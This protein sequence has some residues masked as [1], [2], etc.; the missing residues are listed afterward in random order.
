M[1][2]GGDLRSIQSRFAAYIRDPEGCPPPPD[3]DVARMAVYRELFFNNMESFLSGGFPVLKSI[4]EG[5][6]W[7]SLVRDFYRDHACKT[8]LFIGIGAEFVEYLALRREGCPLGLP[9]LWELAHYEWVELDLSVREAQP[10]PL[11]ESFLKDPFA[12]RPSLSKLSWLL[13]YAFPVHRIGPLHQPEKAEDQPTRLL[14]YRGR[15]E[16]VHFVEL[17]AVTFALLKTL[18]SPEGGLTEQLLAISQSI[19][20]PDPDKVL[21]FGADLLLDLHLK[22]AV[23]A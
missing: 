7:I 19:H 11:N 20:H 3:V 16:T 1:A 21:A 4:L 9:F 13:D 12:W 22:G 14:V 10:P 6:R 23:G 17:N 15:D 18:E 8:P 5:P 2:Q